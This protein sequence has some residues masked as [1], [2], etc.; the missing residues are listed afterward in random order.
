[1]TTEPQQRDLSSSDT[2]SVGALL[3]DVASDLSLLMRQEIELAKAE[4][5]E[6]ATQAG[7]AAGMFS[8]AAMAGHLALLFLSVAAWWG[9]GQAMDNLGWSAVV[10]AVVWAVIAAVLTNT[11]RRRMKNVTGLPRTVDTAKRVPPALK[12]DES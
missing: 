11:A 7:Q 10:V 3:S 4:L 9:L 1:M 6:S 8:G 5:R 2:V 12:G